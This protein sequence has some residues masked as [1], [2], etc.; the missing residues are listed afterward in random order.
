MPTVARSVPA[1]ETPVAVVDLEHDK[2]AVRDVVVSPQ[3]ADAVYISPTCHKCWPCKRNM[4]D[5]VCDEQRRR[6]GQCASMLVRL[7]TPL[8]THCIIF[9]DVQVYVLPH[10]STYDTNEDINAASIDGCVMRASP[11]ARLWICGPGN[12]LSQHR[13][14]APLTQRVRPAHMFRRAP[15]TPE[16]SSE[17][18]V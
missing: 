1:R 11:R 3:A 6:V 13:R 16:G 8:W 15:P 18:V 9:P 5:S 17:L 7:A 4:P 2:H 10:G 12:A 14:L